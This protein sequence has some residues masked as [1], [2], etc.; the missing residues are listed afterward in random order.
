MVRLLIFRKLYPLY[1]LNFINNKHF[2]K[3]LKFLSTYTLDR[4]FVL[5]D[6]FCTL[7]HPMQVNCQPL[8]DV[9]IFIYHFLIH[10]KCNHIW[11]IFFMMVMVVTL[12]NPVMIIVAL[13]FIRHSL[14]SKLPQI[15]KR[16]FNNLLDQFIRQCLRT[17]IEGH[18]LHRVREYFNHHL[19]RY[20]PCVVRV[21]QSKTQF[22]LF[23]NCFIKEGGKSQNEFSE[24]NDFVV[25]CIEDPKEILRI[26]SV[27]ES[28]CL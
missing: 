22:D 27:L 15:S 3:K 16:L 17:T 23:V 20:F 10:L 25:V 18:S 19:L 7:A 1:S 6:K 14:L 24:I 4:C 8:Y 11:F 12:T 26:N 5:Y 21:I 13:I 9:I 28:N 2:I